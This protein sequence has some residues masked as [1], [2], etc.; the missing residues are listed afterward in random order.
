MSP[1]VVI[2]F[3]A[4]NAPAAVVALV[5]PAAIGKVPAAKAEEDVE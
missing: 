2:G 3:K 4:L 5:P 1:V